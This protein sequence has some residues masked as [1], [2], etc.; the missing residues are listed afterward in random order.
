MWNFK[1]YKIG[2][3]YIVSSGLSKSRDQ[4]GFGNPF[5]T[6]K[7]VFYN[8]F[9]PKELENLANTSEK[10]IKSCSVK[11]GDIFLTRTSETANELGMSSV[12][13]CD[14]PKA[15]FNGFTKRLRLKEDVAIEINP[16]FIGYY[17]RSN[18]MRIQFGMH[19]S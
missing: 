14:Y 16:V 18:P 11:K 17:F 7:D 12:A 9:L 1:R 19:S 5:V 15:T 4:F 6:F 13:L 10:E 3:I 2:D 8:Y